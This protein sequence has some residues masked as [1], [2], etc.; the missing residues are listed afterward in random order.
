M[1]TK[2]YWFALRSHVYVEFKKGKI[3]LYDTKTGN[4]VETALE[5]AISLVSQ[6]YEPKNL[7]VTLLSKDVQ[8]DDVQ[9]FVREILEK[10]MGDIT[11]TEKFTV[12]PVR[13]IPILNLQ[14]DMDKLKDKQ[15]IE[16]FIG[17][18]IINYLLEVDIYLN[19]RCDKTCSQC[20]RYCTQLRCCT[21]NNTGDELSVAELENIFKQIRYSPVGRV[22]I[23]GGNILKYGSINKLQES[24]QPFNDT[25]KN[26]LHYYLHYENYEQNEIISSSK[27]ELTVNFPVKKTLFEQIF[28]ILDKEKTTIHFIIENEEQYA[29]A[30]KLTEILHIEKYVMH[31]FYTG[32]NLDFFKDNLFMSREDIFSEVLSI[33]KIFRNQKI[34]SNFFGTLHILPDG[35]VKANMN[36]NAIGNIKQD[37]VLELLYREISENTAWRKIRNSQPCDKCLYQFLCPAP[38]D[39]ER[40]TGQL[41]LCNIVQE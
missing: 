28:S 2:D 18:D 40:A 24:L 11:E 41:N 5:P 7:G 13:L 30:E 26:V 12:K 19:G 14:K 8:K 17:K 21:A 27:L 32:D 6:M 10:Q 15:G 9:N 36:T 20:K 34:N 3:L 23:L 39:C 1:E 38:S 35:T 29:E 33:R 16:T 22:N 4:N 25:F 37:T 31:P